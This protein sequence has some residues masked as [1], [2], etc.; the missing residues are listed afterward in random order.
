M[1]KKKKRFINEDYNLDLSYVRQYEKE[2]TLDNVFK[3]IIK[4]NL[5]VLS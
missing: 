5:C 2:N 4:S 3:I 1:S